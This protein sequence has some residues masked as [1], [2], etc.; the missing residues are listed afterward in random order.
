MGT[1]PSAT[2][3]I[4]LSTL[5]LR[6]ATA[7]LRHLTGSTSISIHAL[8]AESDFRTYGDV[9]QGIEFLS[10][11]S[12]RRATLPRRRRG[13]RLVIS[14]HA[15]LAESDHR[16]VQMQHPRAR[17][18]STL[19]LR[20][21]TTLSR[22]AYS[23]WC[24]FYPRSPCGERP[25]PAAPISRQTRNFYPRSPC[26]ERRFLPLH[27]RQRTQISIH[28]LLAESDIWKLTACRSSLTFLSTLSLR[29]ATGFHF[30]RPGRGI[31]FYPRSPCGERRTAPTGSRRPLHFYPRSP[32][33]ERPCKLCPG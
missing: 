21:A 30:L 24:N 4:F 16:A 13:R 31:N 25:F 6:R 1:A 29:R 15:L 18:L 26:G 20:R 32:C 12:L 23:P 10:T 33:G 19:S 3:L 11:L 8:L 22:Q 5:S 17:F 28:A 2:L 9:V 14:I 7:C 27:I